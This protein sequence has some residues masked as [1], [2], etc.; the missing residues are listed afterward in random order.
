MSDF[1]FNSIKLTCLAWHITFN[2]LWP[3]HD[4]ERKTMNKFN[5][6]PIVP[7]W[8]GSHSLTKT[9]KTTWQQRLKNTLFWSASHTTCLCTPS[10]TDNW[11]ANHLGTSRHQLIHQT[12][13]HHSQRPENC[14]YFRDLREHFHLGNP[15]AVGKETSKWFGGT[16]QV[17]PVGHHFTSCGMGQVKGTSTWQKNANKK[18]GQ[19]NFTAETR[20]RTRTHTHT[21]AHT[22]TGTRTHAQHQNL[23]LNTFFTQRDSNK[24]L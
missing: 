19:T 22:D 13:L 20:T 4:D 18:S 14:I 23:P 8:K 9:L 17:C 2:Y 12:K 5:E 1:C 24:V 21:H 3:C 10:A 7:Y 11:Q 15:Q 16:Q 6:E